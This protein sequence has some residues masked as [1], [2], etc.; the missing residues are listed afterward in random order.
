MARESPALHREA[1]RRAPLSPHPFGD[2]QT[3]RL[4]L[5]GERK[6]VVTDDGEREQNHNNGRGTPDGV[7][8]A[9]GFAVVPVCVTW[10]GIAVA[11]R[12]AGVVRMF[13]VFDDLLCPVVRCGQ[14]IKWT[15][16]GVD[17]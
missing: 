9:E 16:G 17:K 2:R 14:I 11:L 4:P 10:V 7:E 5:R 12:V 13:R 15:V 1:Q 8:G 6:V 3:A